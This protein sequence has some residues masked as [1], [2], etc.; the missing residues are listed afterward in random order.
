M[1]SVNLPCLYGVDFGRLG[2]DVVGPSDNLPR[3]RPALRQPVRTLS[4]LCSDYH[5]GD[6]RVPW[7]RQHRQWKPCE[8]ANQ[9]VGERRPR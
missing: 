5:V 1:R 6:A 3:E 2:H 8:A 9:S 4:N 7:S